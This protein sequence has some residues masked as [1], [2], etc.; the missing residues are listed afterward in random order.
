[1]R[2]KSSTSQTIIVGAG[3]AGL[4]VGAS[5]K[6]AGISSI[7]LEQ[8]DR[9][10]STWYRHYDRLH[11]H[12]DKRNSALP[13][14]PFPED[15]PRYPSRAQV[16]NYLE[17]YSSKFQLDIRFGQKV[18][19][20]KYDSHQWEVQTQTD[21]FRPQ[22]LV[23]ATGYNREPY[24]PA[25]P[26]MESFKGTC[27]HSS[28]YKN[29]GPFRGKK[30]LVVGFGNSGGEIAVDLWEH[31]AYAS[32]A[33][34]SPVNVIPRELFGIPIL[35]IGILQSK[36]PV[37]LADAVNT[38]ILR[39]VIGDLTPYGLPKLPYGP[40]QQIERNA[41]IPL[42]DVG[43]IKLVKQR[44]V[45]VYPGIRQFTE[46]GIIFNDGREMKFDAVILAT[47]YRPRVSAFL[48]GVSGVYDA[49]GTPISG[50][51]ASAV[52]GLFFCGYHVSPTGML[53]EIAMEA[54]HIAASIAHKLI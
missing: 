21:R 23:I 8:N 6:Q 43:T 25:W 26:G 12:T 34:R 9:V 28:Q 36:W 29:G 27:L 30:V 50:G 2:P 19:A 15:Y 14:L 46:E 33:V 40:L 41:R 5:L 18:I 47:G 45:G 10:G 7:I 48:Q 44:E 22:N 42:I 20:A 17:L 32:L 13:Y 53:R 51:D 3:P 39:A 38:P 4:A 24:T 31:A 16:I 11:L 52:P 49:D 37:W 35:S 1:M 54:R